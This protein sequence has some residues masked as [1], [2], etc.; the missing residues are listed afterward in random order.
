MKEIAVVICCHNAEQRIA[1]TIRFLALQKMPNGVEWE[2]IVVDNASQDNTASIATI[3]WQ[4][5]YRGVDAHFKIVNEP[6]T[7]LAFARLTGVVSADAEI[8]I[9]CDDDNHLSDDYLVEARLLL[10]KYAEVGIIGGWAKPRFSVDTEPWLEDLHP[11]LAIGPQAPDE[12]F[13]PWVYGA[14]MVV[15]KQVFL[16]LRNRN[17]KFLLSDRVGS[18]Q[19][20]GGDSEIC[21]LAAYLGYK[22]YYSPKLVL[23]HAVASHRLTQR[24]FIAANYRNVFPIVYLFLLQS[25]ISN[26][27][28]RVNSLYVTFWSRSVRNVLYF[29][30]RLLV[31]KHRFY[32]FLLCYQN[33]QVTFWMLLNRS[34]FNETFSRIKMN[35][36]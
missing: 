17:I 20:S 11:A 3:A 15:R 4:K 5:Y 23:F 18:K 10:D 26:R 1:E 13:V 27:D 19:M 22:I 9:F 25:L 12:G 2:V 30:P 35:L 33:V 6:K 28:S 34:R 14:G 8:I 21:Q 32:S 24:S 36:T 7:G 16:D 29:I 31:G